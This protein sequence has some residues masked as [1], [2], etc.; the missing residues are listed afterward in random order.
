ME[1]YSQTV[2]SRE[3]II[4]ATR[5]F[6]MRSGLASTFIESHGRT[7]IVLNN[8]HLL[9]QGAIASSLKFLALRIEKVPPITPFHISMR[10]KT[11]SDGTTSRFT[12]LDASGDDLDNLLKGGMHNAG[13]AI[14][15]WRKGEA[16]RTLTV[17]ANRPKWLTGI[18]TKK[19]YI[20][21]PD[22]AADI[23]IIRAASPKM[24][25]IEITWSQVQP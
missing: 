11:E 4:D 6:W 12:F 3:D 17:I 10:Q 20:S 23:E 5:V 22:Y 14:M 8:R 15:N 7:K 16:T 21:P 18:F 24:N 2:G 13:E 1:T 19:G 25:Q 9:E